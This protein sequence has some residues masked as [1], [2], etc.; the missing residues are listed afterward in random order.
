MPQLLLK[1][2]V[3]Q[4]LRERE[5]LN[6]LSFSLWSLLPSQACQLTSVSLQPQQ[7]PNLESDEGTGG[8]TCVQG[9]S[10]G[11]QEAEGTSGQKS[12]V[13]PLSTT[14]FQGKSQWLKRFH[15][16][17]TEQVSNLNLLT[18]NVRQE[19]WPATH[20]TLETS[21]PHVVTG[22]LP[23]FSTWPYR[24]FLMPSV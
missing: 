10:H 5:N 13:N 16:G 19:T 8:R 22:L 6:S 24:T 23:E 4:H 11:G 7:H 15:T 3:K 1:E 17:S 21:T 20:C 2:T 18:D 14:T 9:G 12:E